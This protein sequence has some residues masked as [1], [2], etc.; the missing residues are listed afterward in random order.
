M[1]HEHDWKHRPDASG[2]NAQR[3]ECSCGA[4]AY[5][6]WTR[7]GLRPLKEYEPPR[8]A[9]DPIWLG[10]D[11]RDVRDEQERGKWSS[12]NRMVLDPRRLEE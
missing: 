6:M 11:E 5:R 10:L 7:K 2:Y 9:P 3:Y 1:T 8:L 4:W 12:G